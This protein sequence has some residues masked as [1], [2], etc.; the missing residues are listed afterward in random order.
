[1]KTI[2]ISLFMLGAFAL[3]LYWDYQD[4]LNGITC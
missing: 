2:G 3:G 4:C 1:M